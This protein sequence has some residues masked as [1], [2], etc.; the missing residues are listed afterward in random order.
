MS[1]KTILKIILSGIN[2]FKGHSIDI[3]FKNQNIEHFDLAKVKKRQVQI[4]MNEKIK[5]MHNAS[6]AYE[7]GFSYMMML[8]NLLYSV[9]PIIYFNEIKLNEIFLASY[10][11]LNML[12][13]YLINNKDSNARFYFFNKNFR[14]KC[15]DIEFDYYDTDSYLN[16]Q[17]NLFITTKIILNLGL[18][19]DF[20]Y[21]VSSSFEVYNSYDIFVR[22]YT[23]IYT[24]LKAYIYDLLGNL[25]MFFDVKTYSIYD[26]LFFLNVLDLLQDNKS[27]FYNELYNKILVK[28]FLVISHAECVQ[29]TSNDSKKTF[30]FAIDF[31]ETED[32]SVSKTK[33]QFFDAEKNLIYVMIQNCT[34]QIFSLI[35]NGCK[36]NNR[37]PII[38][39]EKL[40]FFHAAKLRFFYQNTID[41]F[42]SECFS[43]EIITKKSIAGKCNFENLFKYIIKDI[44]AIPKI[45][46]VGLSISLEITSLLKDFDVKNND[47]IDKKLQNALINYLQNFFF[48]KDAKII[49]N[50]MTL[51][52]RLL[53]ENIKKSTYKGKNDTLKSFKTYS[54]DLNNAIDFFLTHYF[55][56]IT[57][58]VDLN[59]N[60]FFQKENKFIVCV[61]FNYDAKQI[62][63]L[64]TNFT[65]KNFFHVFLNETFQNFYKMN[66]KS[67]H[68]KIIYIPAQNLNQKEHKIKINNNFDEFLATKKHEIKNSRIFKKYDFLLK[69]KDSD[70]NTRNKLGN[71][72]CDINDEYASLTKIILESDSTNFKKESRQNA[73]MNNAR[74]EHKKTMKKNKP[75]TS[76]NNKKKVKKPETNPNP[77]T[78]LQTNDNSTEATKD[79]KESTTNKAKNGN[80]VEKPVNNYNKTV[81]HVKYKAM[82]SS[83]GIRQT[84]FNDAKKN[85][86]K[87][88]KEY[89]DNYKVF[90]I[91][92]IKFYS[93]QIEEIFNNC[94]EIFNDNEN[95][96]IRLKNEYFHYKSIF[97]NLSLFFDKNKNDFF[98]KFEEAENES[99]APLSNFSNLNKENIKKLLSM[100]NFS[101]KISNNQNLNQYNFSSEIIKKK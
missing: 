54:Y 38:F 71:D 84:N 86:E 10:D 7:N 1:T 60:L 8:I 37:S 32:Y 90:E 22:L 31:F 72:L 65:K 4:S 2:I 11:C 52:E 89:S 78:K 57:E 44:H 91:I 18:S 62:P 53:S 55:I 20:N 34:R 56:E 5:E 48:I 76:A 29:S 45:K 23:K 92:I 98:F 41:I 61:S 94:N 83:E 101:G 43:E 16:K 66:S 3:I 85:L 77:K 51:N 81:S 39:F 58:F 46:Y 47:S 15:E 80:N 6:N 33:I 100:I 24:S 69:N 74:Q 68:F 50:L 28:T 13:D 36:K 97:E 42:D 67:L 64:L 88:K 99:K 63:S 9:K 49:E 19:P 75:K 14:R 70:S 12:N 40:Q 95:I 96:S 73:E 87:F 17:M 25:D 79:K 30:F 26:S 35:I 27:V 82:E 59:T 21:I 93:K